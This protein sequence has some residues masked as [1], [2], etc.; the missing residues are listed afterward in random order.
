M[1]F[2]P[3]ET[4]YRGVTM[5]SRTEAQFAAMFLDD[6]SWEALCPELP[7]P[8]TE[9]WWRMTLGWHPWTYEPRAFQAAD[10]RQY[11]PDFHVLEPDNVIH[12]Y[13]EVKHHRLIRPEI[14]LAMDQLEIVWESEPTASL[15]LV[16]WDW[17]ERRPLALLHALGWGHVK[18]QGDDEC[19]D[20]DLRQVRWQVVI[21][22][23]R[24]VWPGAPL[25][26]MHNTPKFRRELATHGFLLPTATERGLASE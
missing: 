13:I 4:V 22:P 23:G 8:D 11:L 17:R 24:D 16:L 21:G 14:E 6:T 5:R 15:Y 26:W 7:E 19:P 10:G 3:R 12:A 2:H 1:S 18:L 9:A 25:V 20:P